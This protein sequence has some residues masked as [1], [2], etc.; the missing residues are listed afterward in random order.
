[1]KPTITIEIPADCEALVRHVLALQD[2]LDQLALTAPD[3]T[4]LDTC[5][6]AVLEKGRQLNTDIL[7]QAV[8]RRVAAAE[9]KGRRSGPALVAEPRKTGG[10]PPGSS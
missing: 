7:A 3:G 9:K 2:E 4:V 8:A 5:E 6:L 1:M 10:R